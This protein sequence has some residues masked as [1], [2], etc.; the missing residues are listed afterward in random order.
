MK[1]SEITERLLRVTAREL[2]LKP[3]EIKM[4]H[5]FSRDLG[6]DSLQSIELVAAYEEEFNL[7]L[8]EEEALNVQTVGTAVDFFHNLL[9]S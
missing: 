2:K 3:E 7:D 9:V 4:E 8:D 1:K 5:H 6:A